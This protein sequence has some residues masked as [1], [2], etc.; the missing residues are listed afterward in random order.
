MLGKWKEK[1]GKL[2]SDNEPDEHQEAEQVN[3]NL[4]VKAKMTYQYPKNKPFRFPVI[5]DQHSQQP[6]YKQRTNRPA[7]E[8][9]NPVTNRIRT[10]RNRNIE[11]KST[12]TNKI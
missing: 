8:R 3:R 12:R 6:E 9:G 7:Y 4:N 11:N 10:I 2:F 5:P 1:L